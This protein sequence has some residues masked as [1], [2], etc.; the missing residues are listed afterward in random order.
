M[1]IYLFMA[2]LGACIKDAVNIRVMNVNQLGCTVKSIGTSGRK[3]QRGSKNFG[4]FND[5]FSN[6]GHSLSKGTMVKEYR[7][8]HLTPNGHFSG[9]TAPLT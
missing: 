6:T 5:S 8:N 2:S 4:L 1:F 9:R 3:R 7:I